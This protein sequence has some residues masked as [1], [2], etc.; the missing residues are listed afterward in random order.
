MG[1]SLY[2]HGRC[3]AGSAGIQIWSAV[4]GG[5]GRGRR[6]LR[7]HQCRRR[8]RLAPAVACRRLG[9][10]C[11]D[12]LCAVRYTPPDELLRQALTPNPPCTG[13]CSSLRVSRF[14]HRSWLPSTW[15]LASGNS[16]NQLTTT[17]GRSI[18]GRCRQ[19]WRF[20]YLPSRSWLRSEHRGGGRRC[21]VRQS[22]RLGGARCH[23]H[24]HSTQQSRRPRWVVGNRLVDSTPAR[25]CRPRGGETEWGRPH[26]A[27][28]VTSGPAP[29]HTRQNRRTFRYRPFDGD[30][31]RSAGAAA[32][33]PAS[34]GRLVRSRGEE[35][36]PRLGQ[37]SKTTI[38][39]AAAPI[40][41]ATGR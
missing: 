9:A 19:P 30:P 1:T 31:D 20:P 25:R 24:T 12:P 36:R 10:H 21:G 29:A 4:S 14:R 11:G 32:G 37:M 41:S 2:R 28:R 5:A 26:I 27:A 34:V 18:I 17:P 40:A 35:V 22:A 3:T 13:H 16:A 8:V 15:S 39:S 23:C 38:R 33:A 6:D 7:R